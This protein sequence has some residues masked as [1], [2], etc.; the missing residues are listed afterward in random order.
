LI[1]Y[2]LAKKF[3][4][5]RT[6]K[7]I[8]YCE[9]KS[10]TGTARY[11]SIYTHLG[12]E[13]SRRDDLEAI[14]YLLIYFLKGQLPWQGIK[15]KTKEEKYKK[16]TETKI[17][18][19]PDLLCDGL[20]DEFNYYFKYVRELQFDEKPDYAKLKE[21]FSKLFSRCGFIYD[22]VFDWNNTSS[23]DNQQHFFINTI[24]K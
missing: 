21:I 7:H 5:A 23:S 17:S 11:A 12:I 6:S 2:G 1:D 3:Y 8:P 16:I 10:L 24:N 4:D 19:T 13:Q 20:H 22:Y 9:G 15:A 18:S 14:G